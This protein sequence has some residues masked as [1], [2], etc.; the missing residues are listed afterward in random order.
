MLFTAKIDRPVINFKVF[1][2]L[3]STS[4]PNGLA[5][6]SFFMISWFDSIVIGQFYPE[7][8]VGTYAVAYRVALIGSFA[9]LATNSVIGPKVSELY[10]KGDLK[11]LQYEGRKASKLGFWMTFPFLIIIVLFPKFI[12]GIFGEEF[13]S[14]QLVFVMLIL[15]SGQLVAT[16]CGPSGFILQLTGKQRIFK[17]IMI[18]VAGLNVVLNYALVPYY[19]LYGAAITNVI[20]VIIWNLSSSYV[21]NMT[22][23]INIFYIP[24]LSKFIKY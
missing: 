13:E 10:S 19:G 2:P 22:M 4:I 1:R 7:E 17:N 5:A 12:L 18:A 15:I 23:G 21:I 16:I 6:L 20:C 3:L 14:I 8:V 24:G 11:A 9:L